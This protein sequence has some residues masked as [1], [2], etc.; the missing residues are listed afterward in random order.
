MPETAGP[1][2]LPVRVRPFPA[3]TIGSFLSRLGHANS[4]PIPHLLQLAGV[5]LHDVRPFS[6][7]T[8]DRLG[9]PET[10]PGRIAALAGPWPA[11]RRPCPP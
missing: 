10:T 4:I 8:D 5:Q 3:E 11:F 1:R 7:A 2:A 9:W 6:P